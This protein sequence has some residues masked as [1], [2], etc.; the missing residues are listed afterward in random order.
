MTVVTM[1]LAMMMTLAR[2]NLTRAKTS[3]IT[4][5]TM[6]LQIV[7]CHLSPVRDCNLRPWITTGR[8]TSPRCR[9]R[10]GAPTQAGAPA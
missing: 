4:A 9:S 5:M 7:H 6:V 10:V 8:D 1:T 3:E 2:I